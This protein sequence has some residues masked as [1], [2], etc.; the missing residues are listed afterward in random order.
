MTAM[1]ND[2]SGADMAKFMSQSVRS[3]QD[4]IKC[5]LCEHCLCLCNVVFM[6]GSRQIGEYV[7]PK[8]ILR[9]HTVNVCIF[10]S[11]SLNILVD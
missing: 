8:S 11:F 5:A 9:C 7:S 10:F 2:P 3:S 6:Q 4:W 1:G